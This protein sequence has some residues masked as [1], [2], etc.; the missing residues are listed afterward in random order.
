[1]H[2]HRIFILFFLSISGAVFPAAGQEAPAVP[3]RPAEISRLLA[4]RS[5]DDLKL[6][7][8]EA[9]DEESG[10]RVAIDEATR[11]QAGAKGLVEIHRKELEAIKAR[12]EHAKRT[13]NRTSSSPGDK[14]HSCRSG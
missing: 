8:E 14:C 13:K 7:L 5:S 12:V 2:R 6:A 3:E 9:R 4:P 10:A 1:M 11:V